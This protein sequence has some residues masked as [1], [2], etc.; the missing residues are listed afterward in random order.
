MAFSAVVVASE[1]MGMRF[2]DIAGD[3]GEST[4]QRA[5]DKVAVIPVQFAS[6]P[7]AGSGMVSYFAHGLGI[8]P[9]C[10]FSPCLGPGLDPGWELIGTA[11][12]LREDGGHDVSCMGV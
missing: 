9:V 12:E 2:R 7:L 3:K 5:T 10:G 8:G 6:E 4:A 11:E 1:G